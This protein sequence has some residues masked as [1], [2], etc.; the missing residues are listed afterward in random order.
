[1]A[2]KLDIWSFQLTRH[3][4][5]GRTQRRHSSFGIG[6]YGQ[7]WLAGREFLSDLVSQLMRIRHNKLPFFQRGLRAMALIQS[8][9]WFLLSP[10][11]PQNCTDLGAVMLNCATC[12][13]VLEVLFVTQAFSPF[14]V[15]LY[16]GTSVYTSSRFWR[17][18]H[19]LASKALLP[20]EEE[21]LC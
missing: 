9:C 10:P 1:M 4:F 3:P 15:H 16:G 18:H 11:Q 6:L 14:L 7:V 2:I 8:T 21:G 5:R 13:V 19:P 17:S 20:F 12:P